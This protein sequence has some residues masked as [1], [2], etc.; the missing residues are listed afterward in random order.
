MPLKP[1]PYESLITEEI[2][3]SLADLPPNAYTTTRMDAEWMEDALARHVG[4]AVLRHLRD[5]AAGEDPATERAAAARRVLDALAGLIPEAR[6]PWARPAERNDALTWVAPPGERLATAT[7]PELPLHGLVHPSFLFN[8]PTDVKLIGE[9]AREFASAEQVDAVV[10]FLKRSGLRLLLEPLRR[11]RDRCGPDALRLITTTYTGATEA[12]AVDQLASLGFAVKVAREED[13]TRLH[14]KAWCFRRPSGLSTVY[15]G[16][17]NLSHSAMVDGVEWNVRVTQA[18]T[19]ALIERFDTAFGQLWGELGPCYRPKDDM[20]ELRAALARARGEAPAGGTHVVRLGARPKPHQ[21]R[22][23]EELAAERRCGH[24]RNLV[25]AATGTGKTWIAAF[26]YQRLVA[27]HGGLRLLFVAHRKEILTQSL[28]VYRDVLGDPGFGELMVDGQRPTRGTHVFASVQSLDRSKLLA[29]SPDAYDIVVI[30][31]LHHAAAD[32]YL[33]LLEH[34]APRWLVGLT[35]TPER[36]DGKSVLHWFDHRFAT[37]TRLGAALA[38]GLLVPF[39]YFGIADGT[40]AQHAWTRGRVDLAALERVVTADD[41]QANR[42]IDAVRRYTDAGRMRALGFCVGVGH[43]AVMARAF[44]A[45]GLPAVSV[46]ADTP[47]TERRDALAQLA[48]GSLRAVFTVNLFNEGVD[49]PAADTVLFLRPTESATVFLQQLGRGLRRHPG[50]SVLTVLDFV[51][52]LHKD[53]RWETRFLAMAEMRTRREVIDAIEAGFPRLPPGCVI[54]LEQSAQ[55]IVVTHLRQGAK[56]S[57]SR[58]VQELR[59]LG[60][61]TTLADFLTATGATLDEVYANNRGWTRLRREAGFE[62]RPFG[63]DEDEL[64]KR[65]GR[66]LHVDDPLRLDTW[67]RWLAVATAPAPSTPEEETLAWMLFATVGDRTRPLSELPAELARFWAHAPIREELG[68]L[69]DLLSAAPGRER[70]R[71]PAAPVHLHARY[72][73]DEVVAAWRVAAKGRLREL[74]EGVLWV[75]E[76]R[77]DL[78]FVTLDKS[79]QHRP[80]LRY[81]DYP[82]DPHTFHWESQNGTSGDRGVGLRYTQH[83]ERGSQV[84]LF[85]REREKEASGRT[86]PY[87][88]LGRV[89]YRSHQGGRPMQILW[90]LESAMPTALFEAGRATG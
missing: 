41:I 6:E 67:R 73:R 57:R 22:V 59:A 26:D 8:G 63:P 68:Q 30:D 28:Q 35:A 84:V 42:V 82:V 9:L 87:V 7:P 80:Q 76:A 13:G 60:T 31:E 72:S 45:A 33:P 65:V 78:L 5:V 10:A 70:G 46:H 29:L 56:A 27:E 53:F 77:T 36:A 58:L 66:L 39:H 88:C 21:E 3:A 34:L 74:R 48:R 12:D 62:E 32:S 4:R 81:A 52:R 17:S 40:D 83:A 54:Q 71:L 85:V 49:V 44:N 75:E 1:G 64:Q 47:D 38:A 90:E 55:D 15:V 25:V 11:F 19:P 50:K 24:T 16:S 43:A 61:H 2:A 14:A 86:M 23:L 18:I 37:E 79:E 89:R 69:L 20:A 51:G